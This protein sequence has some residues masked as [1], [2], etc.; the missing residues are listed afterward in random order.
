MHVLDNLQLNSKGNITGNIMIEVLTTEIK[1]QLQKCFE[2][3]DESIIIISP[4]L[5]NKT[6]D[7]LCEIVENKGVECIFITRCYIRDFLQNANSIEAIE[8]MVKSGIKVYA[9]EGLHAK[10]YLF[11]DSTVVM[12]S[13]NFTMG[14]LESNVELSLITDEESVVA[15]CGEFAEGLELYCKNNNGLVNEDLIYEMRDAYIDADKRYQSDCGV[16]SRKTFGAKPAGKVYVKNH[17]WK[18]EDFMVVDHDSVFEMMFS[19]GQMIDDYNHNA[20]IKI[21][22]DS[23]N[24]YN[25]NEK[26]SITKVKI[27]GRDAMVINFSRKPGGIQTGDQI[28]IVAMI[29]DESGKSTNRIVGRG[30]AKVRQNQKEVPAEWVNELGYEWMKKYKYFIELTDVE[31]LD[32]NRNDCLSLS[33]VYGALGKRTYTSTISK[34]YVENMALTQC[35]RSHLKLTLDARMYIND[36]LDKL[37]N[38]YGFQKSIEAR[39]R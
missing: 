2:D 31:L 30:Y 26:H 10:L 28:F 11:D 12:G 21:E 8:K 13:A 19:E 17:D 9:L 34:D 24:R 37:A 23:T 15:A 14:G 38:E 18:T 39:I 3:A 35:R 6:A 1:W 5:S 4:F 7:L 29:T 32:M 16:E 36:R 22:G 20:W 27:G 33:E 25:W